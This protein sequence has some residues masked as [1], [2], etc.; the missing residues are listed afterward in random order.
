[1]KYLFSVLVENHAGVLARVSQ[2]FSARGFN[3]T[4]LTVG[5]TEDST[6]SRMT[7]AVDGDERVM[8]QVKKQLNKLIDVIKVVDLT[9]VPQVERELVL[10]KVNATRQTRS[11]IIEI[12]DVFRSKI[13][14]VASN[15]LI[16]EAVGHMIKIDALIKMLKP[17]G[18]KELART[19]Q[20]CMAR[21]E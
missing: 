15:E 13:V 14:H 4:S 9:N 7:I 5:E 2:L 17:Y 21:T 6:I 10:L 19:G 16:I 8:D 12:V 3:I 11:E 1:M 20:V 18:I